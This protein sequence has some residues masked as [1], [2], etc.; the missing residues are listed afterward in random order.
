[1]LAV[2]GV[3]LRAH[4]GGAGAESEH[5]SDERLGLS[6][7]LDYIGDLNDGVLLSLRELA[8]LG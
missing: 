4:Y 8:L 2:E 5:V 7:H 3:Y 1:L 6:M